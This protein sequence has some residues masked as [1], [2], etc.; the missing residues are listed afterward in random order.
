ME[1]L[2]TFPWTPSSTVFFLGELFL[3]A[4]LGQYPNLGVTDAL[5]SISHGTHQYTVRA[6]RDEGMHDGSGY[7][8]R[9][10]S[11]ATAIDANLG[12]RPACAVRVAGLAAVADGLIDRL[13]VGRKSPAPRSGS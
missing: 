11:I 9:S 8:T 13:T 4:G 3:V 12:A 10:P 5:V 1:R 6:S 7:K 2:S